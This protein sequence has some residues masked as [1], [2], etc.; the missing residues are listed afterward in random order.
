[1]KRST[2][3]AGL[4]AMALGVSATAVTAQ[5][6]DRDGDRDRD[7]RN[8]RDRRGRDDHGRHDDRDR[9]DDRDRGRPSRHPHGGPPGHAH[10]G[11]PHRWHRGERLPPSYRTR[12][13]VVD[14]WRGHHLHRPPRG[15]HW[16][17]VGADYVLIAIATGIIAQVILAQ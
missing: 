12:Y 9:R 6:R 14:N 7:G 16:V 3:A 11:P 5:P 4:L 8:D 13:Y 10:A 17:Q 1:M 15:Y 2:F